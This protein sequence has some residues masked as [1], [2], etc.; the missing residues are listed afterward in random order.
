VST[1]RR[2]SALPRRAIAYHERQRGNFERNR[3]KARLPRGDTAA[4]AVRAGAESVR[5]RCARGGRHPASSHA[6]HWTQQ[7]GQF[8]RQ[9]AAEL[10]LRV[11]CDSGCDRLV[12]AAFEDQVSKLVLAGSLIG[13]FVGRMSSRYRWETVWLASS[14]ERPR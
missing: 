14:S 13:A 9:T 12:R 1:V 4:H 10:Q 11:T 8:E 6:G 2:T 7:V 3:T 5:R